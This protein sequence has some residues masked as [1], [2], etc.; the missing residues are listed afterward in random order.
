[1]KETGHNFEY[2]RTRIPFAHVLQA[3]ALASIR[4]GAEL[5]YSPA[6]IKALED[7]EMEA[8]IHGG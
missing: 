8:L 4:N 1:M 7:A 3:H 6:R 2:V 5:T